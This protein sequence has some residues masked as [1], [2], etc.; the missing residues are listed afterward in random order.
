MGLSNEERYVGMVNCIESIREN[1]NRLRDDYYYGSNLKN[2]VKELWPA[3]RSN[4]GN[5]H[6]WIFGSDL[7]SH[8]I[9]NTENPIYVAFREHYRDNES[10]DEYAY[11]PDNFLATKLEMSSVVNDDQLSNIIEIQHAVES[12]RY[13]YNRYQDDFSRKYKHLEVVISNIEM[14]L[15][16][17]FKNN[18]KIYMSWIV[19]NILKKVISPYDGDDF[20]TKF[21]TDNWHDF[22]LSE[23]TDYKKVQHFY[24]SEIQMKIISDFTLE[25]RLVILLGI[26]GR[27]FSDDYQHKKLLKSLE[28]QDVNIET[29]QQCLDN[30]KALKA[31]YTENQKDSYHSYC[32]LS[33]NQM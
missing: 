19:S 28:G 3:L 5:S 29:I 21:A 1:A 11:F 14:E 7:S 22:R 30:C 17:V 2:Y 32:M 6:H 33:L 8:K 4:A 15:F 27:R 26:L 9:S 23:Q 13:Y 31:Q 25:E 10:V 18:P 16:Q 24:F 12:F 20:I